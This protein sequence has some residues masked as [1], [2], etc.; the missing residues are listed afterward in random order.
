MNKFN[1]IAIVGNGKKENLNFYKKEISSMDFLIA[2]NGGS[3]NCYKSGIS[4]DLIIGDMDSLPANIRK[5]Y[6]KKNIKIIP[7][8]SKKDK[9]DTELAVEKALEFRPKEIILLCMAGGRIDH[10]LANI[11]ILE[12]IIANNTKG[13]ILTKKFKVELVNKKTYIHGRQGDIISI[14]S[15]NKKSTGVT[16]KG[17]KYK[18]YN[19]TLFR[20]KSRGISN[21]LEKQKAEIIVKKGLLLVLHIFS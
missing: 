21:I 2:V 8:P 9:S 18:L 13:I 16:L 3:I 14:L 20:D 15:I 17:F 12:K 7:F 1:H 5:F 10:F 6:Q 19:E 11:F 4:P